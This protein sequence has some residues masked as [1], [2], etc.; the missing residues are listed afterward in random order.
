MWLKVLFIEKFKHKWK[1]KWKFENFY[2]IV[3]CMNDYACWKQSFYI[4]FFSFLYISINAVL[5]LSLLK[6]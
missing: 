4:I 1:K 6:M 2:A 3:C 5:F